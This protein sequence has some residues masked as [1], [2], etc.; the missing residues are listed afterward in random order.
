MSEEQ[1][2][3]KPAVAPRVKTRFHEEIVPAL[4]EEFGLTNPFQA[5]SLAKIV[6][7]VG[8]GKQI[9]GTKLKSG[10]KDQVLQDLSLIT[11]QKAVMIRA[12]KSVANFKVREGYE[13][14]S[15]VTLRG[16]RMWEFLDRLITLAIP[17][18]KDFRGLPDKS[19]D[20]RGNYSFGLT[21]QG[22]FPEVD[23][24]NA[25]FTFGMHV[26]FNWKNSTD[27]VTRQAL[28]KMDFPFRKPPKESTKGAKPAATAAA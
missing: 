13:T 1:T 4:R 23:M 24:A 17:R 10:V 20:G 5:P 26:T 18:I 12:K 11:G 21:E 3:V 2:H 9:E 22:I 7:S 27:A 6:V 28:A 19:F 14:A 8:L 15:M 16:D 25:K